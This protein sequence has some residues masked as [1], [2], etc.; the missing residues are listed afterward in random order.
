MNIPLT[1]TP[2][3]FQW[4]EE[5]RSYAASQE[6][7]PYL[8]PLLAAARRIFPK[9]VR[10][11]VYVEQDPELRDVRAIIFDVRAPGMTLAEARVTRKEWN[12]ALFAICPA[13]KVCTFPLRLDIPD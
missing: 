7:E 3:T 2:P 5:V 9:A 1:V 6:V 10:I 12:E 11:E 8:E 13:P 4:S